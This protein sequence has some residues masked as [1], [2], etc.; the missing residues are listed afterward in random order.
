MIL[1]GN[2]IAI[3]FGLARQQHSF[4][5]VVVQGYCV[6]QLNGKRRAARVRLLNP[7]SCSLLTAIR[8]SGLPNALMKNAVYEAGMTNPSVSAL[9]LII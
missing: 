6:F 1:G 9:V 5:E 7:S 4:K 3:G 8:R 2:R